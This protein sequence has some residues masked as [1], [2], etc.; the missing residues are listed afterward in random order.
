M[1]RLV[2]CHAH[3]NQA[4]GVLQQLRYRNAGIRK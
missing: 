1:S 4:M 3:P 2:W